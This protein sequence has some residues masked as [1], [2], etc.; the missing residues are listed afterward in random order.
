MQDLV[1]RPGTEYG[2]LPWEHQILATEPPGKSRHCQSYQVIDNVTFSHRQVET[3]YSIQT[4]W[5]QIEV[6]EY[7]W[8]IRYKTYG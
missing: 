6:A 3:P 4:L 1:P 5:A 2:P 7:I 8:Q